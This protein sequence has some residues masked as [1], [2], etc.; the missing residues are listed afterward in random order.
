M[1]S[2]AGFVENLGNDIYYAKPEQD[3]RIKKD[4][5]ELLERLDPIELPLSE[6]EPTAW[7][8]LVRGL[9][10]R[11]WFDRVRTLVD[12]LESKRPTTPRLRRHYAQALIEDGEFAEAIGILQR[13]LRLAPQE[14]EEH[15]EA[16]GLLGRAFKQIFVKGEREFHRNTAVKAAFEEALHFY[17]RGYE[18]NRVG[19]LAFSFQKASWMGSNYA[20][21]ARRADDLSIDAPQHWQTSAR[22]LLERIL[23][24]RAVNGI[25]AWDYASAG[26]LALVLHDTDRAREMFECYVRDNEKEGFALNSTLR[27]LREVWKIEPD[28]SPAG[29]VV[30]DLMRYAILV[31]RTQIEITPE[32]AK[33]FPSAQKDD[34]GKSEKLLVEAAMAGEAGGDEDALHQQDW[35]D[36]GPL[37]LGMIDSIVR[38]ARS[39]TVQLSD[40]AGV[41]LGTGFILEGKCIDPDAEWRDEAVLVTCAH[42]L[43]GRGGRLRGATAPLHPEAARA[44]RSD[45][46][47]LPLGEIVWEGERNSFDVAIIRF[48]EGAARQ[49]P[50]PEEPRLELRDWLLKDL[51]EGARVFLTGYPGG[52]NLSFSYHPENERLG[53]SNEVEGEAVR[54]RY[55]IENAPGYSGSPVLCFRDGSIGV[56]GIHARGYVREPG[57]FGKRQLPEGEAIWMQSIIDAVRR[58]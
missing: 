16:L 27:Q 3:E 23:R 38:L 25:K 28:E 49:L 41:Q 34:L 54:F 36:E 55:Y 51:E 11:R 2:L 14:D 45:G 15:S 10:R 35:T 8:Y 4:L 24:E 53:L 6:V 39:C 1:L 31:E 33:N 26:E 9:E 52:R 47:E 21:L 57:A 48:A 58:H 40:R 29:R 13:N 22:G 43:S 20:G 42:V 5:D 12:L 30:A 44:T 7:E 18:L 56:I 17:W 32:A 50:K 19:K 46:V 37:A